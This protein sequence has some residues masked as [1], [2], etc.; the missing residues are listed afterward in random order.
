MTRLRTPAVV[1]EAPGEVSVRELELE[2]PGPADVLVEIDFSGVSAGTE[3]LLWSGRMPP[4]PGLGYPLVPGYESVGRIIDA[5]A[6][7]QGR[8][9]QSVF[10]PGSS[11]FRGARGL[12]GGAARR[13]VA[14]SARVIQIPETLGERGALLALAATAGHALACGAPP[15]LIIGHGVLGRLL[16]RMA[17]A[18]GASPVVWEIAARRRAGAVGYEVVDPADDARRDYRA[19]YDVSGDAGLLDT[20]IGR[21]ARGGEIVLAG[22]YE[23][24]LAF[25]FP[26]A[27]MREARLRVAAEFTPADLSGAL[28]Q[29][30][31]GEVDLAD[32]ITHRA[33]ASQASTA[34]GSAFTDP[35]CLKLCLDWRNI[36]SAAAAGVP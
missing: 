9:G 27:F 23:A 5:G 28:G 15:D 2:P 24:R 1:I 32:L 35:D 16:A 8:I 4:F 34:Y 22:F 11:A 25:D 19:I 14:A 36:E 6:D 18:A 33:P 17:V 29:A 7:A 12:F 10:V 26:P 20:L 13:V 30:A 3:K 31:S 21:L